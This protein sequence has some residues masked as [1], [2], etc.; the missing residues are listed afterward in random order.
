MDKL[1]IGEVILKL[2]KKREIT[3]EQLGKFIGVSTAAVSKWE[4]GNS[5]PDITLLPVLAS[6]FNIS[7]DELL[8]YKIELSEKEVMEIFRE[9]EAMFAGENIEKGID[10]AKKYIEKYNSSYYLKLRIGFL[11]N[12]YSWRSGSEKKAEK[13]INYASKLF[14]D[15]EKNCGN[16]EIT[17]QALYLLSGIYLSKDEDDRSVEVLNKIHKSEY[18]IDFMLANIYIKKGDIKKGRKMLQM[19]LWKNIFEMSSVLMCLAKSYLKDKKDLD[20]IEK[21]CNLSIQVKKL[22]SP[23]ADSL[24]GFHIEYMGFAQI[25]LKLGEKEKALDMLKRWINYIEVNNI[26]DPKDFESVWCFNEL[27]S[28]K[29]S[30][31]L[32]MYENMRKILEEDIFDSMRENEYFKIILD[33]VKDME[34][35]TVK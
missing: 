17:E 30:F 2:R 5:Y 28:N 25:Y 24:L 19:Q 3:Q 10:T 32:N 18:N 27:S 11:F 31:T 6:F 16:S 7:I 12:M 22:L 34:R 15:I 1:Q 26:N 9:C 33:K 14:E 23:E 4:V 35:K 8:N 21:Y 20:I 13:M 29:S